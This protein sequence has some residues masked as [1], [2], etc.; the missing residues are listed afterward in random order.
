[1][2]MVSRS[3]SLPWTRFS[4]MASSVRSMYF[5]FNLDAS[6]LATVVFP[7]VGVPVM[8]ITCLGMANHLFCSS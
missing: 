8:R 5:A 1:M 6:A 7:T 3:L 2:M 4:L